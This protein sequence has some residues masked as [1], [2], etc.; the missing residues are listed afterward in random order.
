MCLQE[1]ETLPN[2]SKHSVR[3]KSPEEI[4]HLSLQTSQKKSRYLI[5]LAE[6]AGQIELAIYNA[7]NNYSGNFLEMEMSLFEQ[8]WRVGRWEDFF[9]PR[10]FSAGWLPVTEEP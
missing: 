10:R 3:L 7:G 6:Q 4:V 2:S 1:V 9:S 5:E 8:A